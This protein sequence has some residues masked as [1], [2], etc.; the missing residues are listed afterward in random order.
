MERAISDGG[1]N[2]SPALMK[3]EEDWSV[4]STECLRLPCVSRIS[5]PISDS[6]VGSDVA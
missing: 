3:I 6:E 2:A 5:D 4:T 1:G